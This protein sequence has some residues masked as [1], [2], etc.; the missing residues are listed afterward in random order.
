MRPLF[1]S[2][3]LFCSSCAFLRSSG[4]IECAAPIAD[5][6]MGQ[7]RGALQG[8]PFS[9]LDALLGRLGTAVICAATKIATAP[10]EEFAAPNLERERAAAWLAS[11]RFRVRGIP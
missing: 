2:L 10:Q 1:L 6:V 11:R 5:S 9:V 8:Q 4:I 7:V 3:L